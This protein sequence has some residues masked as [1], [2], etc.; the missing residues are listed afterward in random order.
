MKS[1]ILFFYLIV[2]IPVYPQNVYNNFMKE[3][4]LDRSPSAKAISMGGGLVAYPEYEFSSWY[5]PA[6]VGLSEPITTNFS[7]VSA[8]EKKYLYDFNIS[9]NS[10]RYGAF[11]FSFVCLN[12]N[13]GDGI[14]ES[15][16]EWKYNL[17]NFNYA[18]QPFK[19][20]FA[21]IN[22]NILHIDKII[23]P[24]TIFPIDIGIVKIFQLSDSKNYIHKLTLGSAL[25]NLTNVKVD[26]II[27][28][29]PYTKMSDPLPVIFR[30]GASY[31]FIK[32]VKIKNGNLKLINF[33]G[34]IEIEKLLN[35]GYY[36]TYKAG[37]EITL[38]DAFSFRAGYYDK[39]FNIG[40]NYILNQH[41]FTYGAGLKI[42]FIFLPDFARFNIKFDL[43][44]N[45]QV[46][47]EGY[48]RFYNVHTINLSVRWNE[49]INF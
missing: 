29:E 18:Y 3:F 16:A 5:N 21:G 41:Q 28:E 37:A 48:G 22:L 6:T 4:Y 8:D 11:G 20:F 45:P 46:A 14:P 47:F 36:T 26:K 40:D 30:L 24:Q 49:P 1:L 39:D 38:A 31:N 9:Y 17:Y 2:S 19:Y 34:Q 12:A 23:I 44:F 15:S 42:P 10:G 25:Y 43:S 27:S 32:N 33:I 35:S 13:S 7:Y